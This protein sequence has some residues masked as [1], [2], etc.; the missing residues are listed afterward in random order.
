LHVNAQSLILFY[1]SEV[2]SSAELC[3]KL[4]I[5]MPGMGDSRFE[6]SVVYMC[7]HSDT[8]SMGLIVNKPSREL[9]FDELLEQLGIDKETATD[10]PKV[11]FGGP[12]D[13]G[14]GFVLHSADYGDQDTTMKVDERFGMT[15]SIDVLEDLASGCG[16]KQAL[17]ALGYA[18]WGAGQLD[19]EILR[20][21]W[22]T[23]EATP[24]LVFEA[25]NDSKW[26]LA[27]KSLGIDPLMLSSAAG[28]A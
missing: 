14:R 13:I 12:V 1:M 7:A 11:H 9:N 19:D 26:A 27:L 21:G 2:N 20:N 16:P 23:C 25:K 8:G 6:K 10:S 4:L 18:G 3:G 5:A 15:A 28:R 24:E 17:L 22:L